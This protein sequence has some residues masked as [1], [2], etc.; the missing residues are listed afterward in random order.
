MG[1]VINWEHVLHNLDEYPK[2]LLLVQVLQQITDYKVHAL[3]VAN[4]RITLQESVQ[5][6]P[7]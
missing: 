5:N 2:A 4:C 3:T 7:K 1:V 6:I